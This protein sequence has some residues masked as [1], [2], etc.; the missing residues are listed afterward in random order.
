MAQGLHACT[1]AR[2][3][4]HAHTRTWLPPAQDLLEVGMPHLEQLAR[5]TGLR[6]LL[7][8]LDST[9]ETPAAFFTSG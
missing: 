5:L 3:R 8:Q 9:Q 1:L 4:T 6:A 7:L 2:A